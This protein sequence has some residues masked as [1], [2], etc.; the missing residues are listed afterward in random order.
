MDNPRDFGKK[1]HPQQLVFFNTL[2]NTVIL[3]LP[4]KQYMYQ[5]RFAPM[6]AFLAQ[7]ETD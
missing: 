5:C 2:N 3:S 6:R 4:V 7:R 1:Y